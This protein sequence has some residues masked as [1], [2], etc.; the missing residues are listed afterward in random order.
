MSTTIPA[1]TCPQ[2]AFHGEGPLQ[3]RLVREQDLPAWDRYVCHHPQATVFH[4]PAWSQAVRAAYPRHQPL[5]LAA[6]NDGEMA[7]ILPLFSIKSLFV[8]RVLVSIPYATYGGILADDDASARAILA[9]AQELCRGQ[10]AQYLELRHRDQTD[11]DLPCFGRYDTFR[12][13]L[14]STV[15]DV[16][17]S[18]PRKARA[19]ARH[20]LG[21]LTVDSGPQWLDDIYDL[22]SLTLARL[23]SPNYRKRLFEQLRL[24]YGQ[25]LHC[26]VVLHEGRPVAGVVSFIFRDEITPYFSG[27]MDESKTISASNVM[28]LK[29][30]EYAVAR[31]LRWFDFNRTR[32]DNHGPYDFKRHQGFSPSPL[33]Y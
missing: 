6:W 4:R 16:L 28:Y 33:H 13:P 17:P 22:Y 30:Q 29:L 5:H 15:E 3:V 10:E 14:P 7:G 24:A 1:Q 25:D 32:R 18:L 23:G 9:A 11:L 27:S 21:F 19:A 26:M 8:G 2:G 12:K 31:G 20:G